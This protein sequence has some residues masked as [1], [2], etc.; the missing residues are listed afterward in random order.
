LSKTI[1]FPASTSEDEGK[2]KGRNA[3][4]NIRNKILNHSEE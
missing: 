2:D 1:R 4:G 3:K